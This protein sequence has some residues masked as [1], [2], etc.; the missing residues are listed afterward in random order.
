[1]NKPTTIKWAVLALGCAAL[2]GCGGSAENDGVTISFGGPGA[3]PAV[4]EVPQPKAMG[5]AIALAST[6]PLAQVSLAPS[7]QDFPNPERGFYR[8]ATDPSKITATS[9]DYVVADGQRLDY[10]PADLSAYRTRDLPST[11]LTK[12]NTGFANLRKQASRPWYVLPTTT[13]KPSPT[14]STRRTPRSRASSATSPS[15]SR[16]CRPMRM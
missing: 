5:K 2:A 7:D 12:L 1:M 13:Q 11:Y 8:F 4:A 9:L 14:T 3:P 6:A 16:C 10:T 15:C